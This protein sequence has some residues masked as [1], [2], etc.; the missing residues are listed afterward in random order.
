MTRIYFEGQLIDDDAGHQD[1]VTEWHQQKVEEV[2]SHF[3]HRVRER[4]GSR[5]VY[6]YCNFKGIQQYGD[7]ICRILGV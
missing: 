1:S 5:E 4:F 7:K 6:D 3:R 2:V